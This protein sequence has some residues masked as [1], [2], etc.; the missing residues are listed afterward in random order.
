M[1]TGL[2]GGNVHEMDSGPMQGVI[3]TLSHNP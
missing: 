1:D 2:P 3:P